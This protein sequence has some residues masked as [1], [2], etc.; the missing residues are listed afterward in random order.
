MPNSQ[1]LPDLSHFSCLML[2]A[3]VSGAGR[4]TAVDQLSD[5]GFYKIDHLPLPLFKEFVAHSKL[6]PQKFSRTALLLD[7]D[8][9]DKIDQLLDF[10]RTAVNLSSAVRLCFL[11]ANLESLI[12]R[13]SETRRPHPA[14]D[15]TRHRSI[16]DAINEE[17]H[18]L[19]PLKELAHLTI[20]TSGL[21]VHELKRQIR[22]YAE[23]FGVDRARNVRVNFLSFGF[24]YGLPLD[25][26]LIV[27]VRFL[28]NPHFIPELKPHTGLNSAVASFVLGNSITKDF[29]SRYVD[30]LTFLLPHYVHEGKSSIN[31]GVG[32]TGGRHR[33][34]AIAEELS[35][36]VAGPN[37]LLSVKHRD[38]DQ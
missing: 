18:L 4:T 15:A 35:K 3:G 12:R 24:K 33:S 14:F 10:T 37:Y 13:Y 27:D 30:L 17:R 31:I 32:C 22:T 29:L 16:E 5:L 2:V 38:L 6:F 25:C 8:S 20:D 34:V 36:R 21:N 28:P 11:D 19:F 9:S 23:S 7:I 1:S 26:D